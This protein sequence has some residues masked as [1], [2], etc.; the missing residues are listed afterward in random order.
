MSIVKR[1]AGV[2]LGNRKLLKKRREKKIPGS[3]PSFRPVKCPRPET[4]TLFLHRRM[5]K[6][7]V[8]GGINVPVHFC[9]YQS[10]RRKRGH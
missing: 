2:F 5:Y 3:L 8:G 4:G 7:C 6:Y 1:I 9:K 10:Y